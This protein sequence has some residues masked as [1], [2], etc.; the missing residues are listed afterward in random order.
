MS[1]I[2][3]NFM[4]HK[5]PQQ[6]LSRRG[7]IKGVGGSIVGAAAISTGAAGNSAEK[8]GEVMGPDRITITL[9]VNG[10]T[11]SPDVDPRQT[12]LDT[13]RDYLSLTGAKRVC[14]KGQCGACTVILN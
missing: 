4:S 12:L 1:S 2:L 14:N 13:L 11:Y 10:R 8:Y 3:E 6:G 5:K 7:F 9:T